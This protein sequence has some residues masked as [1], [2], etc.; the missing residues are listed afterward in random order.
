MDCPKILFSGAGVYHYHQ[1][2][3]GQPQNYEIVYYSSSVTKKKSIA[4]APNRNRRQV[5]RKYPFQAGFFEIPLEGEDP[6]VADVENGRGFP[7][8]PGFRKYA[9]IL[10]RHQP[11]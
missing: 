3:A 4:A 6:H 1:F 9:G 5:E 8:P 7:A 11:A 10:Y 2:V